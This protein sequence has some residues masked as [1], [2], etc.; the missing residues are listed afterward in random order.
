MGAYT[1][2][3][4]I[5]DRSGEI[6]AAGIQQGTQA[7]SRG[8]E[9][10]GAQVGKAMQDAI[11]AR[12][13]RAE[14]IKVS[15]NKALID[16]ASQQASFNQTLL[17]QIKDINKENGVV[18]GLMTNE[19]Y[20]GIENKKS[21]IARA[22]ADS[23]NPML[24]EQSILDGQKR[25]QEYEKE[26]VSGLAY[27]SNV[28]LWQK[29]GEA[30]ISNP[31]KYTTYE[32]EGTNIDQARNM[33]M[34][35]SVDLMEGRI[36]NNISFKKIPD[37]NTGMM[38]VKFY[39][40]SG[41]ETFSTNLDMSADDALDS[42]FGEN[43]DFTT[44]IEEANKV[45]TNKDGGL[46]STFYKERVQYT[47]GDKIITRDIYN[48]DEINRAY[49]PAID[50]MVNSLINFGSEQTGKEYR[51]TESWLINMG[52]ETQEV[53]EIMNSENPQPLIKE[54]VTEYVLNQLSNNKFEYR[55]GQF[56]T[57]SEAKISTSGDGEL[58]SA[59]KTAQLFRRAWSKSLADISA[60]NR[61]FV[62]RPVDAD[63][64]LVTDDIKN[65]SGYILY[66]EKQK[67]GNI[68]LEP[69]YSSTKIFTNPEELLQVIGN[70]EADIFSGVKTQ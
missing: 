30:Y 62:A 65:I 44:T 66:G 28:G 12:R 11:Q 16:G 34:A 68:T 29:D 9:A 39:D 4:I 27:A 59:Q 61:K 22:Y 42:F 35:F 51:K 41:S 55:D 24:N 18:A 8:V 46:K 13:E 54:K 49:G 58:T 6:L 7:L 50:T 52:V 3:A 63:G 23:N 32:S 15:N 57:Q 19:V 5:V 48:I 53:K 2:P 31:L 67:E 43:Y 25:V 70:P 64:N 47:E 38:T 1:N 69:V 20:S 26:G 14:K 10:Y 36:S 60:Y 56:F 33:A 37:Y 21:E 45:N 17:T 40:K